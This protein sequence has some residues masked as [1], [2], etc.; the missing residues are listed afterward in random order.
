LFPPWKSTSTSPARAADCTR[1]NDLGHAKMDNQTSEIARAYDEVPYTSRPF[2][3]SQPSRLAALGQM[4]GLTPPCVATARVLELGC[5]AGGNL[6]PLAVAY[7][8]AR[9]IGVDLSGFQIADRAPTLATQA[10]RD[11]LIAKY[12]KR[13]T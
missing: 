13:Y 12:Q 6:I 9:F 1:K 11:P 4:F 10:L 8:D 3:Q 5:A 7:P 2:P